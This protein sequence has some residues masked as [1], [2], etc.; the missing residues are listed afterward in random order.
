MKLCP[1]FLFCSYHIVVRTK[2]KRGAHKEIAKCVTD[3]TGNK[4]ET[5]VSLT[6]PKPLIWEKT[7]SQQP[8]E[9]T[10][11]KIKKFNKLFIYKHN[12]DL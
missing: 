11:T 1:P 3:A 8:K 10:E 12:T 5:N 4:R 7:L 9:H 6:P 2:E